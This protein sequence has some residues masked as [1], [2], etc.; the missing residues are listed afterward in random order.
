MSRY[1]TAKIAV[2]ANTNVQVAGGTAGT[3]STR[4]RMVTLKCAFQFTSTAGV[5]SVAEDAASLTAS[6][7]F[8]IFPDATTLQS[9]DENFELTSDDEVWVRSTQAGSL[10]VKWTGA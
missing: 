6:E 9:D 5:V 10:Y 3:V 7:G 8:P 2:A 4:G 1:K